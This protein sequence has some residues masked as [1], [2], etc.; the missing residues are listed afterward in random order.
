M[1]R[2]T[3]GTRTE[4]LIVCASTMA[5]MIVEM[6]GGCARGFQVQRSRIS[7]ATAYYCI[8]LQR[9]RIFS[10]RDPK[11]LA[12]PT[13]VGAHR[14]DVSTAHRPDHHTQPMHQ[15]QT[16]WVQTPPPKRWRML[17]GGPEF[18]PPRGGAQALGGSRHILAQWCVHTHA[19]LD[20]L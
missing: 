1:N 18:P 11:K 8:L 9:S 2:S 20:P 16:L 7:T 13:I 10:A 3:C 14:Q 19:C 12:S 17:L 15:V 6:F 5:A 4:A